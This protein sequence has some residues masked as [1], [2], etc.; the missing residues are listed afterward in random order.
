MAAERVYA[1]FLEDKICYN[2]DVYPLTDTNWIAFIRLLRDESSTFY[3][4]VFSRQ[5]LYILNVAKLE[6]CR[7]GHWVDIVIQVNTMAAGK[8]YSCAHC[9]EKKEEKMKLREINKKVSQVLLTK[10][11]LCSMCMANVKKNTTASCLPCGHQFHQHCIM[12]WLCKYKKNC[13]LCRADI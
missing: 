1:L 5:Q 3:G 4:K 12:Q 10:K 6:K 2:N 13:P 9:A 7:C 11:S 8:Q